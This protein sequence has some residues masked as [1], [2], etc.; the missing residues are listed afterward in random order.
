MTKLS[1]MIVGGAALGA[2]GL[3]LGR[4]TRRRWRTASERAIRQLTAA[5]AAERT[6]GYLQPVNELP[7]PVRR[8]FAVVLQE[9]QPWIRLATV[10]WCGAFRLV[11]DAHLD[12]RWR[13]CR[14]NQVFTTAPPGFLWD[15]QIRMAP[16]VATL[17]RDAY[18]GGR[19]SMQVAALGLF[20]G[21]RSQDG[22]E[23]NASALQRYLGEAVWFPTALLP[24][25]RLRWQPIDDRSAR[26]V[27]TDGPTTVSMDFEFAA[28]GEIISTWTPGRYRATDGALTSTP[29]GGVYWR[30]ADRQGIRIPLEAEAYWTLGGRAVPYWR[31]TVDDIEYDTFDVRL[32]S[33]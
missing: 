10:R 24:S 9:G 4:T 7:D 32:Q 17:I 26:A 28:S 27:L 22:P 12:A 13:V 6:H 21:A 29:F 2:G 11:D 8:Y 14:A 18:I 1:R 19:C 5:A 33:S 25:A 20:R 3:L 15:A 31:G 23:L 30:Y 16:F